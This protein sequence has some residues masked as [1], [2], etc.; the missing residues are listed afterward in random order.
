MGYR[1]RDQD[2]AE[3]MFGFL[4]KYASLMH[5]YRLSL[6]LSPW[7]TAITV[8]LF[9]AGL[10]GGLVLAPADYQQGDSFRIIYVHV[11][12]AWMSLFV[13]MNMAACAVSVLIWRVKISEIALLASAP[14]RRVVHLSC[15][16]N[17]RYLGANRCGVHGGFGMRV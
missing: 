9:A 14:F 3:L 10:I 15:A 7:F 2:S 8:L 4:N 16:H 12:S 5:F 1:R 13:Y 11:P 6:R 17:R